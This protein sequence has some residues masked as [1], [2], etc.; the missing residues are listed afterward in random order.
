MSDATA[1]ERCEQMLGEFAEWV[2]A[3]ARETHRRLMESEA[4]EDFTA[5]TNALHKLGRGL[6]Q[7][8]V[9]QKKFERERLAGEAAKRMQAEINRPPDPRG[10]KRSRLSSAI[11]RVVW[12]E[13]EDFDEDDVERFM[14]DVDDRLY[15]LA[16]A[17]DFMATP[18]ESLIAQLCEEF[19]LHVPAHI[20]KALAIVSESGSSTPGTASARPVTPTPHSPLQKHKGRAPDLAIRNPAKVTQPL[21]S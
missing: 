17:E 19:D 11:E 6:R 16:Q 20:I 18:N 2:H 12:N 1:P 5:Y 10:W 7:A 13:H 3:A 4:V 21:E 15:A 14:G 9:L 8:L